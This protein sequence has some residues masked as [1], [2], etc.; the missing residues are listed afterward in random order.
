[1]TE[2]EIKENMIRI[3]LQGICQDCIYLDKVVPIIRKR[4]SE[5]YINGL[6]QSR[7]DKRMLE[8]ENQ[9]LIREIQ[10]KDKYL[11][12]IVVIGYDYDGFNEAESLKGLIDELVRFAKMAL[13]NDDKTSIAIDSNDKKMNIL[14]EIIESEADHDN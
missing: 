9:Q 11:D 8:L 5:A 2:K 12:L 4:L 6:E 3:S 14:G 10:I 1:M 7:F 13:D